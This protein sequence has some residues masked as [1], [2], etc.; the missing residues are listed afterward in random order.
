VPAPPVAAVCPW[1]WIVVPANRPRRSVCYSGQVVDERQTG[2][3]RPARAAALQLLSRRPLTAEELLRR[4][5]QRGF[6]TAKSERIVR[7][8][9]REGWIDDLGLARHYITV[10]SERLGHGRERLLRE[11]VERGVDRETAERA[12]NELLEERQVE[13]GRILTSQAASRLEREGGRLDRRAYRRV[14][15]SLLRA[16]FDPNDIRTE[17]KPYRDF[18]D[19]VDD[20]VA[21]GSD[22]DIP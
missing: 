8:L 15:N 19:D 16:G 7:E 12:W 13:P 22:H 14:Y 6:E 11:L 1:E 18:S 3:G 17:L 2:A 4:L 9:E 10:R 20:A 21:N 5:E